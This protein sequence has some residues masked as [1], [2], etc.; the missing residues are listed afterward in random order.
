MTEK[1]YNLAQLKFDIV[2]LLRKP[3][4]TTEVR[5]ISL[6]VP[7]IDEEAGFKPLSA[8]QGTIKLLKADDTIECF[9]EDMRIAAEVPCHRCLQPFHYDV[10][11]Q[12]ATRS[13][14]LD[15]KNKVH[16]DDI[17]IDRKN[18]ELDANEVVRQEIIL[19]FP[20]VLVCFSG[21]KGICEQ[22]GANLNEKDCGCKKIEKDENVT[23]KKPLSN[24]KE[25]WKNLNNQ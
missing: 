12:E 9:L 13:F 20:I 14:Y 22:C 17:A 1:T 7:F 4:G 5:D 6:T 25:M 16:A 23:S 18:M 2:E 10:H 21:C 19:H 11:I 8:L 15:P 24:L 3:N